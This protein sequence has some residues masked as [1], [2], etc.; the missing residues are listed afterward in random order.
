VGA[1]PQPTT[2]V[3]ADER[4]EKGRK[5]GIRREKRSFLTISRNH[6][7]ITNRK[8]DIPV[9]HKEANRNAQK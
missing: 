8:L 3:T 5:I 1:T 6:K 2:G 4:W 9:N 7:K